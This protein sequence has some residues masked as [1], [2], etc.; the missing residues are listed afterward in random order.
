MI[1][2]SAQTRP[3]RFDINKN[4]L[5]HYRLIELAA[6]NGA[7]LLLFPELSISGYERERAGEFAFEPN[8]KRLDKL[9]RLS[10]KNQIVVVAGAPV[11]MANN[12]YIGAFVIQPDETISVYTKQFLHG[13][14]NNYFAAS[15][16]HNPQIKIEDEQFSLAICADINNPQH[17]E[18]AKKMGATI[19]MAGIFFEPHEMTKAHLILS[20]YAKT[21]SI[22]VLMSNFAGCPYGLSGGGESAFWNKKGELV[23]SLNGSEQGILFIEK[24]GENWKEKII[25]R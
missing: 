1:I 22:N 12:L 4:L 3:T 18:N 25:P 21:Q 5:A 20:G 14:E 11:L 9:R 23:A 24:K 17:P 2:A 8:D 6:R 10:A 7:D 16:D 13:E 15:A 19:Y